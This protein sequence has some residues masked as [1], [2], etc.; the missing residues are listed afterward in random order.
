MDMWAKGTLRDFNTVDIAVTGD[1]VSKAIVTEWTIEARNQK[2]SGIVA[3]L[4]TS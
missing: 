4:T 1:S 3:D 2:A